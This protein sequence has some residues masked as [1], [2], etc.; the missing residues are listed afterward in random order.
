MTQAGLDAYQAQEETDTADSRDHKNSVNIE[1]LKA[2]L[3]NDAEIFRL[4]EEKPPSRQKQLAGFYCDAKT[5]KTRK[6]RQAKIVEA[7]RSGYKGM[8]Y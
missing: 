7:L 5:E 4:F 3:A 2:A 6:K 8:L 1:T